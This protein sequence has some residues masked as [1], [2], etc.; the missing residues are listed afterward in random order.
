MK[1]SNKEKHTA[2]GGWF[3]T[4]TWSSYSVFKG[5]FNNWVKDTFSSSLVEA[6][7]LIQNAIDFV[8]PVATHSIP[9]GVFTEQ[10]LPARSQALAWVDALEPLYKILSSVGMSSKEAW[11]RVLIFTKAVYDD[12]R[13]VRGLTLDKKNTAG[14][15]WGSFRTTKLLEEY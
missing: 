15:F 3:W 2:T 4:N 1:K 13:A 10:L 7:R 5:M 12:G 14:M 6:L 11:E 8:F 9:H